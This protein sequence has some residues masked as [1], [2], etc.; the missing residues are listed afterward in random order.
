MRTKVLKAN[1][2]GAVGC[3]VEALRRG[4]LV[5]FPTD[6]VYGVGCDP[7]NAEAILALYAAKK[8][9]R[10]MPIPVLL[11]SAEA[12]SAVARS[13]PAGYDELA[14]TFWPGGLTLVVPKRPEVPSSLTAGG[15][16]IAVRLP[17]H[18]VAR[19]LADGI[20]GCLAATSANRS[21]EPASVDAASALSALGGVVSVLLDGGQCPGGIASTVVG[22]MS[23]PPRV[24]RQGA[25]PYEALAQRLPKLRPTT[26]QP[27]ARG[28]LW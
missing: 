22:L 2:V 14:G 27:L 7:W 20:G 12:A 16:S 8:R 1:D 4:E 18:A 25:I 11:A 23:D 13:L 21:G 19:S 9:P 26:A 5:A 17:D 10:S 6:T 15:D 24:L 28:S 3:A